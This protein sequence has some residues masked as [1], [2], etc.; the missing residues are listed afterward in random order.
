MF[1]QFLPTANSNCERSPA[2][3]SF[4][5][6][7]QPRNCQKFSVGIMC[8]ETGTET[9][10]QNSLTRGG[11]LRCKPSKSYSGPLVAVQSKHRPGSNLLT[12]IYCCPV[13]LCN[14]PLFP[15]KIAD[16]PLLIQSAKPM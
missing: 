9:S 10:L 16:L 15:T 12:P 2:V 1:S 4:Y 7:T 8:N 5:P 13:F 14:P 3:G 11:R 6:S